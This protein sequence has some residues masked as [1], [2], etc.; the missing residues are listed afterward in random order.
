VIED[1]EERP[2]SIVAGDVAPERVP[3]SPG[4]SAR[5]REA[6]GPMTRAMLLSNVVLA[7]EHAAGVSAPVGD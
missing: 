5:T 4:S 2:Q 1:V 6:S 7:A 3:T